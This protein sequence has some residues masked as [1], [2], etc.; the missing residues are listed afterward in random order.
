MRRLIWDEQVGVD[1]EGEPV[2]A[3]RDGEAVGVYREKG[4]TIIVVACDDGPIRELDA[5]EYRPA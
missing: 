5:S 4:K 1:G 3:R 2:M